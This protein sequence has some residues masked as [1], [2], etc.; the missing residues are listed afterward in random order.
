MIA[1][2]GLTT[3][4]IDEFENRIGGDVGSV[5]RRPFRRWRLLQNG[6]DRAF[7][8]GQTRNVQVHK[9]ICT[10]T[11]EERIDEMIESKR[12]LAESV[13]GAPS[14]RAHELADERSKH[15]GAELSRV[16]EPIAKL[17]R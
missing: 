3:S 10:G 7:R 11:L 5:N 12:A 2:R 4:L 13:L 14:Q 1:D 9:F 16:A 15:R 6:L 17:P 8:I